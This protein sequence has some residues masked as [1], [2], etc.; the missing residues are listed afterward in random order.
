[1]LFIEYDVRPDGQIELVALVNAIDEDGQDPSGH[2]W[3]EWRSSDDFDDKGLGSVG[4]QPDDLADMEATTDPEA[5]R[6]IVERI[7]LADRA[8]KEELPS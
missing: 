2:A 4:V 1:M 8:V 5:L 7:I 6:S 3:M